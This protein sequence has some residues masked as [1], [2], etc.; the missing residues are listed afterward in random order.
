MASENLIEV[1]NLKKYFKVGKDAVLKAVDDV[2]FDIKKGE[3]LGLVGESGCGK[4]TCGRT[5]MGLYSATGGTV[6]FDGVEIHSLNKHDKKKFAR[7]AQI[8]FQDP[9]ASLNPRMTVGDIIG[10]GIDIH[11][12]HK[13]QERTDRIF[14]LLE[15]V[16]LN[17]EH[18]SRFPHEFSGGQRQRIGIARALAIE[19]DFIVCDEPISALDVS[20]QA[21]VVNLLIKLQRELGLT[22][23]FIAHDLSMV[24]HISDRV[25][26]M[27][28]GTMVELAS[29]HDLYSKPLHPYTQALLSAIP[30][31]DPEVEKNRQRI[32]LEGEV[33]SPINPKPGCRFAARCKYAKPICSEQSPVFK[34]VEKEHFVACHLY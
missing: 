3:T 5:V 13:G 10:E 26:V 2:S 27:Y 24:K 6:T 15:L 16:G 11:N 8:I 12:L 1:R 34:E 17:K 14:K 31:P 4:T 28:L 32:M 19:P 25:G 23:L 21:Q 33:P 18:A 29:S 7:R 20:I 30:I 9:Y 22:Y